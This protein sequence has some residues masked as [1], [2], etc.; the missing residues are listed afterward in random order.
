M[1]HIAIKIENKE[2]GLIFHMLFTPKE[3][4]QSKIFIGAV[5]MKIEN[6]KQS[7]IYVDS[8][9]MSILDL[10]NQVYEHE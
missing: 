3:A 2:H 6:E 9:F 8:K 4:A 10:Y 1:R 5:E 7:E